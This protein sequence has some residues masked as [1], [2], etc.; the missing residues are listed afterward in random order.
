MKKR[1]ESELSGN[2]VIARQSPDCIFTLFVR[3]MSTL[4]PIRKRLY[5][6]INV[7]FKS[8]NETKLQY[9]RCADQLNKI[10][11]NSNL[12]WIL[13]KSDCDRSIV[14]INSTY[15]AINDGQD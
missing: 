11:N 15:R 6:T 9:N 12:E 5:F 1:I 8:K 7:N 3:E 10:L 13:M 4:S 14:N 2:S